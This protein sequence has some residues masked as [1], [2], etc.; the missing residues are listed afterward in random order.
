MATTSVPR[1]S[2]IPTSTP[3]PVP[4]I[5]PEFWATVGVSPETL[6]ALQTSTSSQEL[7]DIA[8]M[9][10]DGTHYQQLT[11][12]GYNRDPRLSPDWQ[13]IAY[14]SVPLSIVSSPDRDTRLKEGKYNVWVITV[15]GKQAWKLTDSEQ[16]RSIPDW[17]P[18][19]RKVLFSEG[20]A[21]ALIELEVD[22][23][24]RREITR[25]VYSP[26]YR[27]G[28]GVGYLTEGGG[29]AWIDEALAVHPLVAAETLPPHTRVNNFV[30]LQDGQHVVYTLLDEPADV[31]HLPESSVWIIDANGE[32]PTQLV[33]P[34]TSV[35]YADLPLSADNRFIAAREYAYG[36]AC[37]PAVVAEFLALASDLKSARSFQLESFAG[38]PADLMGA[39][40]PV[41]NLVWISDQWA[42]GRFQVTCADASL[43]G[44]YLINPVEQRVIQVTRD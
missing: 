5:A 9:S 7:G 23:Q 24:T 11:N 2:S 17:L 34:I 6:I 39:P 28:G 25:G 20:T 43:F 27:P 29:L 44:W 15:D 31:W 18:D 32:N 16:P 26:R 37:A 1:P 35:V 41:S 40:F 13:R 3:A 4:T 22:T 19:S 10:V 30:W 14:R 21:G 33:A 8:V 12:Y 42:M 36:D 38:L